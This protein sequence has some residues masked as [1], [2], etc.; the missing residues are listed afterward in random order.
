MAANTHIMKLFE[1]IYKRGNTVIV[2]THEEDIAL[3]ARRIIR[4]RDGKIESDTVN[5][6]PAMEI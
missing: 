2:V 3:H 5:P 4:L 1:D 6:H